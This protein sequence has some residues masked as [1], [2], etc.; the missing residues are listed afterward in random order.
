[1][2][3]V[4]FGAINLAEWSFVSGRCHIKDK[5]N[6]WLSNTPFSMLKLCRIAPRRKRTS[7]ETVSFWLNQTGYEVTNGIW[8]RSLGGYV[9]HLAPRHKRAFLFCATH[10]SGRSRGA[11]PGGQIEDGNTRFFL[12]KINTMQFFCRFVT[13]YGDFFLQEIL[14]RSKGWP[15]LGFGQGAERAD[16]SPW[17]VV[18]GVAELVEETSVFWCQETTREIDAKNLAA[19]RKTSSLFFRTNLVCRKL[20]VE[21]LK[22][23]QPWEFGMTKGA[24][25]CYLFSSTLESVSWHL[26]VGQ[27]ITSHHP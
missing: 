9:L 18:P 23:L 27:R 5:N 11:I 10:G 8:T 1:M 2:F 26:H 24:T 12:I 16:A 20:D 14:G 13:T 15:H 25:E 21:L 19:L 3:H 17:E 22:S 7:H 6:V 4:F